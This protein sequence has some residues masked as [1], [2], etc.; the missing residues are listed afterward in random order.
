MRMRSIRAFDWLLLLIL[1]HKEKQTKDILGLKIKPRI[2]TFT[3][4]YE[5]LL[6]TKIF[7]AVF[8]KAATTVAT[9]FQNSFITKSSCKYPE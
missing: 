6:E 4:N 3:H 9:L 7:I 2:A 5:R 1:V 8:E